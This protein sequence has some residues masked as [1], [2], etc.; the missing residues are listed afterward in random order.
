MGQSEHQNREILFRNRGG[1]SVHIQ[2]KL[3]VKLHSEAL[4]SS[5]EVCQQNNHRMCTVCIEKW[6]E[7]EL[8]NQETWRGAVYWRSADMFMYMSSNLS[9]PSYIQ[10]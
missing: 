9:R 8:E 1:L 6:V 7:L 4:I 5:A 10:T 3:N 2:V